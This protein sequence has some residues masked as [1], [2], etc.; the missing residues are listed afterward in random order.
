MLISD[1]D[2]GT[3]GPIA[4]YALRKKKNLRQFLV[5]DAREDFGIQWSSLENTILKIFANFICSRE[6]FKSSRKKMFFVRRFFKDLNKIV[7]VRSFFSSREHFF[8]LKSSPKA[9]FFSWFWRTLLTTRE[10]GEDFF[11][12]KSIPVRLTSLTGKK[13]HC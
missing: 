7:F 2:S 12:I 8:T 11:H 4:Y 10:I 6:D 3:R 13:C 1:A 5:K 9:A